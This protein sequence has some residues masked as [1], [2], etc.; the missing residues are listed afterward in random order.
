MVVPAEAVRDEPSYHDRELFVHW[1]S[2]LS[3]VST[4]LLSSSLNLVTCP[5]LEVLVRDALL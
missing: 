4:K 5:F 1:S 3:N 2:S